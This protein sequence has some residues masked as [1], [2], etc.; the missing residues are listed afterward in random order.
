MNQ[1]KNVILLVA[2]SLRYDTV[3]GINRTLL[4]YLDEHSKI[5]HQTYSAGSWTLPAT[6]S[7]FTGLLPHEHHATTR[8]RKGLDNENSTLAEKL[9]KQGFE[10]I[11]LT[12]NSVTTNIFGLDRGFQRTEKAWQ[13]VN[14]ANIPL[15]N[16]ILMMS[17]RRMRRKI[18]QGDFIG[19]KMTEDVKAGQVWFRSLG[20]MQ[21]ARAAEILRTNTQNNKRTFL[22]INLMETHFPY[23][24]SPKFK[25][26]SRQTPAKIQ[27][28]A[29][30]YHLVNQSW[31]TSGKRYIPPAMLQNLRHRQ[32]I[33]WKRIA[34]KIDQFAQHIAKLC[35]QTLF[36]FTSDHGDNFGDENWW[37]HFSNTTEAGN[38]VPLFICTPDC[39]ASTE[40]WAPFST[41]RLYDFIIQSVQQPIGQ[42]NLDQ[43]FQHSPCLQSF[44]YDM[45]GKTLPRYRYDQFGFIYDDQRY[46]KHHDKWVSFQTTRFNSMSAKEEAVCG[47]PI[48][49]LNMPQSEKDYLAKTMENFTKFS[50]II[51]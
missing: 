49:D 31:L 21:L 10:T 39:S 33:A 48:F 9:K 18:I 15:L 50:Q 30:L 45:K 41:A 13:K 43:F 32:Q 46:I 47:N 36:I 24:I 38:R 35:P 16:I 1:Y 29:S 27:E 8:T 2:D 51:S 19:G 12:A 34:P 7:I 6:A 23:H 25:P 14:T 42:C 28:I 3:W 4:P 22:F 5:F 44:W 17:K 37:Y 20:D 40:I 26:I 11:Q